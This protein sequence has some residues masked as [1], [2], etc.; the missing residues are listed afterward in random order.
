MSGAVLDNG[1]DE[2]V[3]VK[4]EPVECAAGDCDIFYFF[5]HRFYR[6]G[7]CLCL[8]NSLTSAMEI[9]P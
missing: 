4:F 7:M 6:I 9:S 2:A 1:R 3:G 8:R 5:C